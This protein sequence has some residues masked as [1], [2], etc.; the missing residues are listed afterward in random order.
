MKI[1]IGDQQIVDRFQKHVDR[2]VF[3]RNVDEKVTKE[4]QELKKSQ[5]LNVKDKIK[6][7]EQP[8][9]GDS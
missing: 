3:S 5:Q 4:I 2:G 6:R 7:M 9:D 8:K 1:E